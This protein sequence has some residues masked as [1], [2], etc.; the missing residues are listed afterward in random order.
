MIRIGEESGQVPDLP[1]GGFSQMSLKLIAI[2]LDG[3][4][5]NSDHMTMQ[6]ENR[7]AIER[8]INKGIHVVPTT[9][10]TLYDIPEF[11]RKLPGIKYIITSNGA[12]VRDTETGD[13]LFSSHVPLDIAFEV[14]AAAEEKLVYT[15]VYTGG[16]AFVQKNL[17]SEKIEKSPMFALF[18]LLNKRNEEDSLADFIKRNPDPVEKIELLTESSSVSQTITEQLQKLPVAV[19][20]S[21]MNSVEITNLSTDKA[22]G[23]EKLCG[24]L[25]VKPEE[26]MAIG[27]SM[28]DKEMLDWAGI[29]VAVENADEQLKE[30]AE[31]VTLSN[32]ECG[33]AFAID[34]FI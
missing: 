23:L 14:L 12:E 10:R 1:F 6:P 7:Q 16:R 28:N 30:A 21:G 31:F 20:T 22:L 25:G 13:M 34:K 18:R 15:E 29:P 3:T 33:V 17:R 9:G 11:I 4:L 8:A 2:D 27:D 26:V 5:L 24:L 19:T 32:E